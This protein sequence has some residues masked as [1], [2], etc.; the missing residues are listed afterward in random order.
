MESLVINNGFK[1]MNHDE[2]LEVDGG[3]PWIPIIIICLAVAASTKGC[4][5]AHK[6]DQ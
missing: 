2:M 3:G 1:E 5:D 6:E 4:A